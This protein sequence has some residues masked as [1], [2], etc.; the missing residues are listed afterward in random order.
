MIH[1]YPEDT[2]NP[3]AFIDPIRPSGNVKTPPT[4]AT[5][6]NYYQFVCFIPVCS[7]H[8]VAP[9]IAGKYQEANLS[10]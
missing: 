7:K 10:R 1:F 9:D 2:P 8:A 5:N 4:I 6:S 3:T